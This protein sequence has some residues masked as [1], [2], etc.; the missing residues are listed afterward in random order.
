M[1]S[2][3]DTK[4][5]RRSPLGSAKC[6]THARGAASCGRDARP[7]LYKQNSLR[8]RLFWLFCSLLRACLRLPGSIGLLVLALFLHS[9]VR[10]HMFSLPLGSVT[11]V[12]DTFAFFRA[13]SAATLAF[14][15]VLP[16]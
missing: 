5:G 4:A 10:F 15:L 16:I 3:Q 6:H 12:D 13:I 14:S 8:L 9:A 11:S 2:M 7:Q 1:R